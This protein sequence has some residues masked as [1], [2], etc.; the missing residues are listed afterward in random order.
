MAADSRQARFQSRR[1][2]QL[3]LRDIYGVYVE[4]EKGGERYFAIREAYVWPSNRPAGHGERVATFPLKYPLNNR[5]YADPLTYA[6]RVCKVD[7]FTED[8]QRG[9]VDLV[10]HALGQWQTATDG[11]VKMV[12]ESGPCADYSHA[13]AKTQERIQGRLRRP[14]TPTEQV[15]LEEFIRG[16]DKWM[17]INGA[18]RELNEVKI[19]DTTQDTIYYNLGLI[20]AWGGVADVLGFAFCFPGGLACA[21]FVPQFGDLHPE[22]G[23]TTDILFDGGRYR[24]SDYFSPATPTRV[25]FNLCIFPSNSKESPVVHEAGHAL[26][27]RF[28]NTGSGQGVHHPQIYDSALTS[29][30]CSPTPFD[31]MAIYA[32]YQT[33]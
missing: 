1:L 4:Y 5:D 29:N 18:D 7:H 24:I 9:W 31:V 25:R 17:T 33:R 32:M 15:E 27:I 10:K 22:K 8:Q 30:F 23:P 28:G 6:Y 13:I 26:G 11:L 2:T 20:A 12:Y 21:V 16:T 3:Q 19:I 14:L